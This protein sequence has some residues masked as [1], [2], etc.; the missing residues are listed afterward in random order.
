MM[1]DKFFKRL[2][3]SP[4]KKADETLKS[5]KYCINTYQEF[6]GNKLIE[7]S[8]E[9]D[10]LDYIE[11]LRENEKNKESSIAL[12]CAKLRQF[13]AF[14]YEENDEKKYR[15]FVKLLKGKIP[16]KEISPK[17]IYSPEEIKRLI[18]VATLEQDRAIVSILYESGM[19][20]G[21]FIALKISMVELDE[22]KQEVIF[23][24][25]NQEGCKT[26][27]RDVLCTDVYGYVQD[28][29]KCHPFP[30]DLDSAF[31]QLKEFA[32]RNRLRNLEGRAQIKKPI[33]PHNFRHSSITN[34][35]IIK[36]QPN[37]ISMRYWGIPNSNMLST[38]LHLSEQI[39]NSGYRDAKGMGNGNGQTI[40][41]PLASR[42][43][44]C[45]HLI[46]SGN[47]CKTCQDSKKLSTENEML[48]A[49]IQR[50][51]EEKLVEKHEHEQ[52]LESLKLEMDAKM[53][54]MEKTINNF[55]KNLQKPIL[56]V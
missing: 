40:I 10:L 53:S 52:D 13:F 3:S 33:N 35:C 11:Y 22:I 32:I 46:Q 49:E 37:Q 9:N 51:H 23:H 36:M 30:N 47:L 2:S 34:A 20:I 18:N 43:V 16:G 5:I 25:P 38:Y 17:D 8:T 6:I 19:R 15:K 4:K 1:K 50:I 41:N 28:W 7:N 31:I 27:S 54:G 39:V 45:G 26:G 24:I 29:L 14:C 55:L 56:G 21:E 12:H 44:N 42:C 48:K